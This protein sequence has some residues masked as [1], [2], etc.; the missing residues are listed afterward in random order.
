[1]KLGM[2]PGLFDRLVHLFRVV[3]RV[4]DPVLKKLGAIL[5]ALNVLPSDL[6][7]A[8]GALLAPQSREAGVVFLKMLSKW[9][10]E[11]HSAA[12]EGKKVILVFYPGDDTPVCTR[13][14]CNLRDNW[15][16]L[17]SAGA[18]VYGVNP[19]GKDSHGRFR[20]KNQL[21][22]PL[23]VDED[24]HIARMYNCSGVLVKRTVYVLNEAGIIIYAKRGKPS[25]AEIVNAIQ[26]H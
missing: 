24:R 26:R 2:S 18:T 19:G 10:V 8:A 6:A 1:M 17:Q 21:P 9:I 23:L 16:L 4:P 25:A 20:Q 3:N 5:M 22:F 7:S 13:Q 12:R 15:N 14:L 11:A